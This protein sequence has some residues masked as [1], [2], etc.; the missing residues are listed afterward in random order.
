MTETHDVTAVVTIGRNVGD[1]PLSNIR[2]EAYQY[3]VNRVIAGVT[4]NVFLTPSFAGSSQRGVWDGGSEESAVWAFTFDSAGY[5]EDRLRQRLA[6]VASW[7]D[8]EAIG[9]IIQ[10]EPGT[11]VFNADK[12]FVR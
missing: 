9:L 5:N 7:Y 8:Q 12:N 10:R 11:L 1:E 2:W 3:D 4:D 6:N